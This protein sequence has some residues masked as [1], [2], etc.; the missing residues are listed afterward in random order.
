[1]EFVDNANFDF[2][3]QNGQSSKRQLSNTNRNAADASNSPILPFHKQ[4]IEAES[5]KELGEHSKRLN[6]KPKLSQRIALLM[7]D[8]TS[9]AL[10]KVV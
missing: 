5:I 3:I 7:L 4:S 9:N 1:M 6:E 10:R 2:R 8:Y